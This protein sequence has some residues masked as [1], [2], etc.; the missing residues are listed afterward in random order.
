MAELMPYGPQ[1]L[2]LVQYVT[3]IYD[4]ANTQRNVESAY[5]AGELAYQIELA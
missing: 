4:M 5:K 2:A 1:L 3:A